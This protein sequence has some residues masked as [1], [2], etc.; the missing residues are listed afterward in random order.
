VPDT[1]A[2]ERAEQAARAASRDDAGVMEPPEP[3]TWY[4]FTTTARNPD[5]KN[6]HGQVYENLYSIQ[7]G[8]LAVKGDRILAAARKVVRDRR[9]NPPRRRDYAQHLRG[10]GLLLQRLATLPPCL[11]SLTLCLVSVTLC[12]RKLA[13]P[14]FQL[15]LQSFD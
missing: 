12:F 11:V 4:K 1:Y 14:G 10:R 15:L 8:V 9:L 6:D 7:G 5:G 13:G 3:V 2:K